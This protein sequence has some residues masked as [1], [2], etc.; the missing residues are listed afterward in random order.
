M[1]S[2]SDRRSV[3]RTGVALGAFGVAGCL[4]VPEDD[5]SDGSPAD[6]DSSGT[7]T[8]G[9]E[10]PPSTVDTWPQFQY[11]AQNT[12]AVDAAGPQ[13]GVQIRWRVDVGEQMP[14]TPV[15]ADGTVYAASRD[16]TVHAIDLE[17]GDTDWER[18]VGAPVRE[19][20]ALYGDLVL[21]PNESGVTA[22][23][24]GTGDEVWTYGTDNHPTS[25][26]VDRGTVFFGDGG[27]SFFAVDAASGDENWTIRDNTDS[28]VFNQAPAVSENYVF[29]GG[30]DDDLV[31]FDRDR[32]ESRRLLGGE[33]A[34]VTTAVTVIDD[35]VVFGGADGDVFAYEGLGEQV[36]SQRWHFRAEEYIPFSPIH[37]HNKFIIQSQSK[38]YCIDE[39]NGDEMWDIQIESDRQRNC[40]ILL[41]QT[42]F[43]VLPA[44]NSENIFTI[45]LMSGDI[46]NEYTINPLTPTKPLS[47]NGTL[48]CGDEVRG[49]VVTIEDPSPDN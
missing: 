25:L 49:E 41:G 9:G 40:P 35:S 8:D 18:R 38:M 22:L 45:D 37:S 44:L 10:G 11:D 2:G 43:T 7:D 21:L 6:T 29:I 46:T 30:G 26:T 13:D 17:S 5:G 1:A 19:T 42:V 28:Q 3:L 12:G 31:R 39:V 48:V 14:S 20:P 24:Q 33:D 15:A 4:G 16:G 47:I 23:Q 36:L 27:P 34:V 32:G